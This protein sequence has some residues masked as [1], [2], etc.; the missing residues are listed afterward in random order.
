MYIYDLSD[1][2]DKALSY[3]VQL[4]RELKSDLVI[5]HI[6]NQRD[7]DAIQEATTRLAAIS[8]GS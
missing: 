3:A 1:C 4:A 8:C 2:A 6:I 5:S 7:A